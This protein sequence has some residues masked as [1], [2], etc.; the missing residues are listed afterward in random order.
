VL[1]EGEEEYMGMASPEHDPGDSQHGQA[2]EVFHGL[3]T[4]KGAN[5]LVFI[6]ISMFAFIT[7]IMSFFAYG[8]KCK[9]CSCET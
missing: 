6:N 8:I 5:S 1:E 3:S 9:D 7:A 4:A 2:R